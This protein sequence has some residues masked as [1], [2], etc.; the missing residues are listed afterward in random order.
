MFNSAYMPLGGNARFVQAAEKFD[1]AHG[2]DPVFIGTAGAGGYYLFADGATRDYDAGC[3]AAGVEPP[4]DEDERI[5]RILRWHEVHAKDAIGKF[6]RRRSDLEAQTRRAEEYAGRS[7]G[8]QP[9]TDEQI[10]EL[11]ELHIKARVRMEL[12]AKARE[13]Y[14]DREH[15]GVEMRRVY[16]ENI[17]D[18]AH[19]QL[20]KIEA[21]QL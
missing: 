4:A 13:K 12:L 1:A 3:L 20:A 15:P 2:G 21:L 19:R 17:R 6:N 18:E 7:N 5:L 9:P 10:A 8:P 16:A 14:G 11:K